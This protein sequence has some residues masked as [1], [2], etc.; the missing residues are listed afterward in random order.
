MNVR[1]HYVPNAIVFITQVV[2][3]RVPVFCEPRHTHLLR[4]VLHQVKERHPFVM[5]GYVFLPDHLHLLVRPTG[6][7]NFS[8]IMHSMKRN[9]TLH[10]K[11][12]MGIN[13]ATQL[14]QKGFWDHVIRNEDDLQRH[15]DYIHYNPVRHGLVTKPEGWTYSSFGAWQARNAYPERWGWSLPGSLRDYQWDHAE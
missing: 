11:E 5:L 2:A 12:R 3:D 10:Y 4:E 6:K 1:R 7:S 9:F 13:S 14:W 8:D 15:L